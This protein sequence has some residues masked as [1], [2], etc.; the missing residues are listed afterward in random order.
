MAQR[1]VR[2]LCTACRI[3]YTPEAQ[4]LSALG[5]GGQK[6]LGQTVYRA[7]ECAACR[8]GYTGRIGIYELHVLHAE[9][10]EAI[11]TQGSLSALREIAARQQTPTMM[12]DAL[13][14]I[15]HGTTSVDE[16]LGALGRT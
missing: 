15:L 12:N 6:L 5:E 3:P 11:R 7:G 2:R 14:K 16:V 8:E 10:Q 4:E 1:L 9:M 13:A